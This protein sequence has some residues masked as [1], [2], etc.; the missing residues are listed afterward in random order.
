METVSDVPRLRH[1]VAAWKR[2]G[3][4][5]G[6]VPTMGA[7][8]EGHLALVR[9]ARE[10]SDR[11]VASVFVNPTQ[12]GPHE[13]LARY[14]RTPER[15]AALLASTG[16]DLL[17]LPAVETIYPPGHAT[18]VEPGGAALGL[19]GE[20]RPG[21]FRGVATVVTQLFQLVQPDVAVFG[22]KDAQQLAVVRQ[23]VRDLHLP[24]EIVAGETVR[25]SDGLA[26]SSRNV[27]LDAE[28]RRAAAVL[29]RA[30]RAAEALV[31]AGERDAEAV[32]ARL[33]A[34]LAEEQRAVVDYAAVVDA[35]SFQPV[36]SLEGSVVLPIAVR[37]GDVR[38][39]DNL[40]L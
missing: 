29:R 14:P 36:E 13:D 1:D 31:G 34:V 38:L 30:L 11:V 9:L 33:L 26:R 5:V 22:E 18:F 4:V 21:H 15:D 20:R 10:R 24:V 8:H 39:I 19:E 17:F 25:E 16:C 40:R 7:L 28:E 12:F 35:E 27:Y 32:R 2:A 6:F 37:I 23:L 3:D